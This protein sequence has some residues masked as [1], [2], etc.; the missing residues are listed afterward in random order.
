MTRACRTS[1]SCPIRL[2]RAAAAAYCP[3]G[4]ARSNRAVSAGRASASMIAACKQT[5]KA[6][7]EATSTATSSQQE[8]QIA[9]L[10][11]Q[12]LLETG[13]VNI[14]NMCKEHEHQHKLK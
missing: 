9:R 5:I 2:Y 12:R 3:S 4:W 14:E 11:M 13:G 6:S 8:Q 7:H 10:C 1:G